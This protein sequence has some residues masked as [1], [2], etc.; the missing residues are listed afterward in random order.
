MFLNYFKFAWRNLLRHRHFT[1]LNVLGL[2]VGVAAALLLFMAVRYE[3]SFDNF[4]TNGDRIYRVVRKTVFR[5]GNEAF[6][7]GYPLPMAAALRT[8][9]PQFETIVPVFATLRPQVTVLGRTPNATRTATKFLEERE[10]FLAGPEFFQL[11]HFPFRI[12]TPAALA[13]PNVVVLTESYARKYFGRIEQAVGQYLL[14]N[15]K[16]P[17]QVVG[18]LAD[19]PKN[20][21]F[22]LNLVISY[23]TKRRD[24]SGSFG[25]T[26]FDDWGA[27]SSN[28]QLFVRLPLNFPVTQADGLLATFSRRHFDEGTNNDKKTHFLSPLADLHHDDRF[29]GFSPKISPV[30]RQRLW[31]MV[32]V[33][34]LIL[35]MACINFVNI[36]LALATKRTKEVGVRKVLGSQKSQLV[37]QFLIETVL[38]VVASIGIGAGLV[39]SALPLLG[40]LFG[41]P[42]DPAL[43]FSPDLGLGLLS[44]LV[45]LTALAG[46]YPALVLSSFSP[47]VAFRN[48]VAS[49]GGLS[50]RQG[51]IVAQFTAA[52]VLLISTAVNL[53]QMDF[54]SRMDLGFAKEGIFY[55]GMDREYSPRNATLRNELLRIPGVSSV[56]FF[57]DLPSSGTKF[58]SNFAFTDMAR[59]EDF[60]VSMKM[61]DGDYCKTYGIRLVAGAS[62]ATNDTVPKFLVNETLLK[63]LNIQNP[64]TVIGRKLRLGGSPPAEIV[65]VVNDFQTNSARDGGVQPM[66]ILPDTHFFNGGSVQLRSTNLA[67]TAEQIKAIYAR[68]YPEVAFSGKFYDEE[69]NTY[70][71]ADQQLGLLYRVFA[72][73]T[74][75]IACLGLF[76]LATFTAEQRTKEIGVRKVLGA[77]ISSIV[78]LLSKD[79]LKLVLI[80]IVIA[81]PIAYYAMNR[82]LQDFAHR[83]DISGWVFALSGL[84]AVGIALL[85]VSYQS[86]K[87][88]LMNPAKSLRSE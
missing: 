45:G 2:S 63:K 17:M 77:S 52:L 8:D 56:S 83:I 71:A 16:F 66:V 88:A 86:I 37:T 48:R 72:G 29:N 87:A 27:S 9:I 81:S 35:L 39:Y 46:L 64:A 78:A 61:A 4:H 26:S 18:V 47:L 55:F 51:L 42:T 80:A 60:P 3:F 31:N 21:S 69:L 6:T 44:L 10:G 79:F 58:Q 15:N 33:G 11:F 62:Y 74:L 12:G 41:L 50:L 34:A 54:L 43:Y 19:P 82:W 23:E 7:P 32:A 1:L 25:V 28:D 84:L 70:Y 68:V 75:F 24:F 38:M 73:L 85:T 76:G 30:P 53:Q 49:E 65:G 36:A 67:R 14:I 5:N 57:S 59:D 40:T 22:P 13:R 20:T